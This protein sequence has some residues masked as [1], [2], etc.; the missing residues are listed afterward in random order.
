MSREIDAASNVRTVQEVPVIGD[1]ADADD[2][3]LELVPK[4][5]AGVLLPI[6]TDGEL[7]TAGTAVEGVLIYDSTTNKIMFHNGS[8]WETVTSS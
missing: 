8:A 3:N 7:D 2:M 4:G 5:D 6:K 1:D